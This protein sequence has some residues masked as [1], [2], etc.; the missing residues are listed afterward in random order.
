[1]LQTQT[2]HKLGRT[3]LLSS[4]S[5]EFSLLFGPVFNLRL[6]GSGLDGWLLA[7]LAHFTN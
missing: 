2:A 3:A 6:V 4:H 5:S 1:M 7:D